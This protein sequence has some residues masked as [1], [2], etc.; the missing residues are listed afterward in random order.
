LD[1]TC[2]C[3]PHHT[4]I[5]LITEKRGA[6]QDGRGK[7]VEGVLRGRSGGKKPLGRRRSRRGIILRWILKKFDEE[8]TAFTRL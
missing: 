7:C 3:T 5:R 4:V 6:G 2:P 1:D 8:W